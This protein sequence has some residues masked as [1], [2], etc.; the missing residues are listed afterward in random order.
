M[1]WREDARPCTS[2]EG[3]KP[4]LGGGRIREVAVFSG[5][6]V[7]AVRGIAGEANVT[8]D[9]DGAGRKARQIG[10]INTCQA[11][12]PGSTRL[13]MDTGSRPG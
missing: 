9:D 4:G 12:S 6:S 13:C 1:R 10:G 5:I 3:A 8:H 2:R 7:R 11:R